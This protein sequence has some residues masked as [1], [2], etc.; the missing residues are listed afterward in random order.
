VARRDHE[1]SIMFQRAFEQ[2]TSAGILLPCIT[3]ILQ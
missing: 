2:Q 1:A 3:E